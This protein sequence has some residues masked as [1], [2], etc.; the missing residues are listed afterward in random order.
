MSLSKITKSAFFPGLKD[1]NSFSA[2]EAYAASR[3]M[4][5]NACVR[6]R[7]SFGYLGCGGSLVNL[8]QAKR[9]QEREKALTSL[10]THEVRCH[11]LINEKQ[12][13][14]ILRGD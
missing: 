12:Q 3:V 2:K 10:P 1:P 9:L 14:R 8:T 5:F 4:P 13:H 6:E 7:L 11:K